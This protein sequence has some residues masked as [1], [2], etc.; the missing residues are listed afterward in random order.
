MEL[1]SNQSVKILLNKVFEINQKSY[2][3]IMMLDFPKMLHQPKIER[4][5]P[6][7][8]RDHDEYK[9]TQEDLDNIKL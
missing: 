6:F 2:Q 9:K 4:L 7:L 3:E 5:Y 8:E 1:N